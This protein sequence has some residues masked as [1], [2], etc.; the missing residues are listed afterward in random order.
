MSEHDAIER[1]STPNTRSTLTAELRA[2]GVSAEA[3]GQLGRA[4]LIVHSSLSRL[5]WVCGGPVAV[6]QALLDAV[7]PEGDL[8]MPAQTT[9]YADPARWTSPAVPPE[10]WPTIRAELPLFDPL[11]TP[12][13][14][15]GRIAE[16]FLRWP[17]TRRSTHPCVSF[18]AKGPRADF[19]L[20]PHP[21]TPSFGDA[22]PLGRLY[23]LDARILLLGTEYDSCTALHLAE[24]RARGGP[25][26]VRGVPAVD[27]SGR[28]VWQEYV[29]VAYDADRFVWIGHDYEKRRQPPDLRKGYVGSATTRLLRLRPLI[30]HATAWLE[31]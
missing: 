11:I 15:M 29:D 25:Q 16:T 6:C 8:V 27:A 13:R 28:R 17:G 23:D 24:A 2:L 18:T 30:D 1:R 21:L 26:A 5:G 22:S 10:W 31:G 20:H 7:G 12:T 4:P 3:D 9:E 14:E 19:I